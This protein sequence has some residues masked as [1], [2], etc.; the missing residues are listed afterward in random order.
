MLK[1]L[2]IYFKEMFPLI[3]SLCLGCAIFGEIYL[4]LLLNYGITDFNIGIQ[5]IIGAFT[6]FVFFLLLRIVDDFKDYETDLIKHPERPVP[7]GRVKKTDLKIFGITVFAVTAV[8]NLIY[9]NN[10][11]FFAATILYGAFMSVW[12]CKSEKLK[13]DFIF[14]MFTHTPYLWL[15]NVYVIAFTCI[16]YGISFLAPIPILLSLTIYLIGFIRGIARQ[17]EIPISKFKKDLVYLVIMM[18]LYSLV[19]IG[20]V[21]NINFIAI[22]ILVANLIWILFKVKQ[23]TKTPEKFKIINKA[24]IYV[25]IQE[26]TM[27]LSIILYLIIGKI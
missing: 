3:P 12:F 22:A 2:G 26:I 13:T 18:I 7:S 9:M 1:R 21:W 4:L 10:F 17:I 5:E 6:V 23:F 24:I 15:I 8:L 16:K 27:V 19:G 11:V 20:L 14:M 25:A